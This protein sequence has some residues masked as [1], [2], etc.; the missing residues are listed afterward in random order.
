MFLKSGTCRLVFVEQRF[1][2]AFLAEAAR[3]GVRP[4]LSTRVAGF[5]INSGRR[6]DIGA[7]AVDP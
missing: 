7:Y 2:E 1:E 6:L 5:N 4:K 3:I